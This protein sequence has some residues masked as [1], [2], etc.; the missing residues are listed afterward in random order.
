[1]RL[2]S[3]CFARAAGVAALPKAWRA[4]L[5]SAADRRAKEFHALSDVSFELSQG[6]SLG[7]IGRNGSGKSTLLQ[8][9]AGTL[10]PSSGQTIVRGRTAALLE[11]GSGFNLEFSGRENVLLQAALYGVSRRE[12]MERFEQVAAFANIGEF[13]EQPVKVYSSGMMVR[14]A[15]ATQTVLNPDLF[16]VD[17]ALSVGDV[18]FQARCAKFFEEKLREGMSLILVSHDL[19]SVKAL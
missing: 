10:Q 19:M 8:I 9:L 14:L 17:E 6:E 7:I 11:L 5:R 12:E 16:I 13:I 1:D 3:A 18:F 4:R 15:F 2:T